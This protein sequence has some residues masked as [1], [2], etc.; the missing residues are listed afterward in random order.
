M[1]VGAEQ[2]EVAGIGGSVRDA[3]VEAPLIDRA[4]ICAVSFPVDVVD[5]E[6]SGVVIAAYE[7]F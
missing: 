3:L 4:T 5:L 1:A 6:G 7:A 2:L